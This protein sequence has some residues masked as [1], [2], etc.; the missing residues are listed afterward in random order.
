MVARVS[1]E[2]PCSVRVHELSKMRLT[3][4]AVGERHEQRLLRGVLERDHVLALEPAI[5]GVVRRGGDLG[6]AQSRQI[7]TLVGDERPG[8]GAGDELLLERRLQGRGFLVDL[9]QSRLVGLGEAGAGAHEVVVVHLEQH[10]RFRIERELVALGMDRLDPGEQ[11]RIHVDGVVVRGKL[12]RLLGLDAVE[13][14]VG[15]GLDHGVERLVHAV[16]HA[17]RLLHGDDRV[18]ERRRGGIVGDRLD[19][20]EMLPHP[21]LEGG[22][23]VAVPDLVEGRRLK[24]QRA[25]R[26]ERIALAGGDGG[27]GGEERDGGGAEDHEMYARHEEPSLKNA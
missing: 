17:P 20:G 22:L 24:G 14:V 19:L 25:R 9:A 23:V 26:G 11:L 16:E 21:L 12:G 15:V 27:N 18:C 13:H 10:P 6:V 1:V 7:G 2:S 3:H 4:R 8:L 5:L